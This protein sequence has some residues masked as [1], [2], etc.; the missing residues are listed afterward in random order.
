MLDHPERLKIARLSPMPVIPACDK[1][2][3]TTSLHPEYWLAP[4]D[5]P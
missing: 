3:N 2:Y 4:R 1:L 5:L